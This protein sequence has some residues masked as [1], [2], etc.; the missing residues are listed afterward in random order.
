MKNTK[1][2]FAQTLGQQY[3]SAHRVLLTGTPLQNNLAEL[4]ALLNFLLPSIF[5]SC[6]EFKKW[7]DQP[8]SKSHPLTNKQVQKNVGQDSMFD[9]SEEEQLLIINRLHQVLRPFLLRRVKAEVEKELPPK[10]ETLVKVELSAWQR[11]VYNGI[12]EHGILAID[13]ASGKSGTKSFSN[14]LMKMRTICNHPYLLLDEYPLSLDWY[15]MSSGKFELLDRL[16]PKLIN[17][18]HKVLIFSQFVQLINLLMIFLQIRNIP[19][20]KLDGTMDQT[21][22]NINLKKFAHDDCPERVFLLSTRAGGTGLNLQMADTVIIYDSDFNPQMDEQAKD[23]VHRI[24]Q[25]N[26]VRVLRL[27]SSNTIEENIY[28]KAMSKKD[29][30]NKII[31]AGMFNNKGSEAERVNR[32]RDLLKSKETGKP[33]D[34]SEEEPFEIMGDEEI[35]ELLART[36]CINCMKTKQVCDGHELDLFNKLDEERYKAEDKD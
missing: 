32:L 6:D 35:N 17:S 15:F 14:A 4:W 18:G 7:F 34:D 21:D 10:S 2:K 30:D 36:T 31:Q 23:R 33:E 9:L 1:S 29:L 22:R 8:L 27:V 16:L 20:L 12:A 28:E 26:E 24:G 11:I 13:P 25:K 19:A 5:S 3:I